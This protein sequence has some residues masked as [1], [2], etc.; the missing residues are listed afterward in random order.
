[1][2]SRNRANLKARLGIATAVLVGG[3][4][5]GVA[6]VAA[7]NHGTTT[8]TQSA[9]YTLNFRHTV[10]MG[11]ALSSALSSLQSSHQG[12]ALTELAQ[13]Q[14]MRNFAQT[15]HHHATLAAQ[16]GVVELASKHFLLV[17]SANGSLHLWWLAGT[18]VI[19]VTSSTTGMTAMTGNN[20]AASAAMTTGNMTPAT[21]TMAGSISAANSMAASAVKPTTVTVSSGNATITITITSSSATVSAPATTPATTTNTASTSATGAVASGPTVLARQRAF[22]QSKGVARGDMVFV[23]GFR[24]HGFLIAKLVL[25]AAQGTTTTA[26]PTATPPSTAT[27]TP[28]APATVAPTSTATFSNTHS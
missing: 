10:P 2:T 23:A 4:A 27:M 8:K 7:S 22:S 1:M 6:A 19:N 9:G 25:F 21:V 11:T 13:M 5:I 15:R 18:K 28:T 17:K 12:R 20:S 3:G 26:T 14:S 16:R 24:E